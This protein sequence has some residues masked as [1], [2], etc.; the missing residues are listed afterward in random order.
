MGFLDRFR[1]TE[2]S[3]P[4]QVE[5]IIF[6]DDDCTEL[7]AAVGESN[8]QSALITLCGSQ[9]WEHVAFD[10][11]AALVPEPDNPHDPNAIAVQV[12]GH[13]VGYLSR[14]E[15]RAYRRL[16]DD[17]NPQYIACKARIAGR[18][19]GSETPNLGIFLRL[20]PPTETIDR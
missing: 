14:A 1:S 18:E 17:A 6:E 9:R 19:E 10:C 12:Q 16:V 7:V 15:A 8:Y 3:G 2:G 13:L 11:V 20:P 5:A 4:R